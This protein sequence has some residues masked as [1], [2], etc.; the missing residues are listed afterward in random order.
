MDEAGPSHLKKSG[1]NAA[2]G[3][4]WIGAA[5]FFTSF[6]AYLYTLAPT[7]CPGDSGELIAS[8]VCLGN[9]HNPGYPLHALVGKLF[10]L[11]PIGN[12]AFR[13]NLM[14]AVF[15]ALTVWLV[16]ET[17]REATGKII[18]AL[19]ASLILAFSDAYWPQATGAEVY[20]LHT[21]FVAAIFRLLF[22][23]NRYRAF[24][25]LLV[26]AFVTGLSFSNHL[27]TVML[28]PAV[29]LFVAWTDTD[30]IK[31]LKNLALLTLFLFLGLSVYIYLPVR[32]EAGTPISFGSPDTLDHFLGL[33]TAADHRNAYLLTDSWAIYG[34]RI[35]DVIKDIVSLF[36]LLF[37]VA[38]VGWIS[39]SAGKHRVF[40]VLVILFDG[41]YT[42]FLNTVPL[43]ITPFHLATTLA[44]AVLMGH[45]FAWLLNNLSVLTSTPRGLIRQPLMLAPLCLPVVVLI[46]NFPQNDQRQNYTAY[47][48]GTNILRSLP[49][50]ATLI[51]DEDNNVFP[52]CYLYLA[53]GARPDVTLYDRQNQIFTM[54][55]LYEDH[56]V[57]FGKWKDLRR[58]VERKLITTRPHVYM[59]TFD[60]REFS[61]EG[62]KLIPNGVTYRAVPET[63]YAASLRNQDSPWPYYMRESLDE[64]FRRDY[65][66]RSL[67]GYFFFK[68]GRDLVFMD[69][70]HTAKKLL[71][72][73]STSA[74]DDP[75]V[76]TELAR[77]YTNIGMYDEALEALETASR[78]STDL[79]ELYN[80]WGFFYAKQGKPGPAIQA[81]D[82]AIAADP[83]EADTY[84]NLGLMYLETGQPT[85]AREA[86][87]RSL[88]L[89]DDQPRLKRLMVM[90]EL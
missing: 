73:A 82:Q 66:T 17:I 29:L 28:A 37:P 89:D 87:E 22:L 24:P 52:L 67:T 12:P 40:W 55:F 71:R 39:Q 21:F 79:S 7:V 60:D 43:T 18:P 61:A 88:D 8:A 19:S 72:R 58:I 36:P 20:A 53:E 57:F 49:Q 5:A 38:I 33:I 75:C 65:F 30:S 3:P 42:V 84:R 9:A 16:Y 85:A 64:S 86:F 44:L 2:Q 27:Q 11:I 13:V 83:D 35:L 41:V 48:H 80:V 70:H 10:T 31:R 46:T 6:I 45:G 4:F 59:A 50:G 62:C 68:M 56:T 54:P 63:S 15:A 14:S 76:Q 23:W 69:K 1:T 74:Y 32:T 47:E 51:A 78:Y 25:Y 90:K 81:Y 77:F 26:L 34:P